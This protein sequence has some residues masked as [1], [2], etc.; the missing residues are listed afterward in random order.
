[1]SFGCRRGYPVQKPVEIPPH[2][3]VTANHHGGDPVRVANIRQR[4][5]I[6]QHEVGGRTWLD[7]A[8]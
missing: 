6:E 1:M 2:Q 7:S 4:I 5:A 8:G 3:H